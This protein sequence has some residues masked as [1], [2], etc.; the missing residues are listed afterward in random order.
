MCRSTF[1]AVALIIVHLKSQP[2]TVAL[3]PP[4]SKHA[5]PVGPLCVSNRGFGT[6]YGGENI[7]LSQS[8]DL[9]LLEQAIP[10]P[11]SWLCSPTASC[12]VT[13]SLL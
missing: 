13:L 6:L 9:L 3:L 7:G 12:E 4:G 10:V 11:P 1:K 5:N 2:W 8:K